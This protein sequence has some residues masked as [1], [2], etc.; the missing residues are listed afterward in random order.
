MA[1]GALSRPDDNFNPENDGAT[2]FLN[3][4]NKVYGR[5]ENSEPTGQYH[6][7]VGFIYK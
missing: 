3:K 6:G 5:R 4:V 1:R 2:F 7:A